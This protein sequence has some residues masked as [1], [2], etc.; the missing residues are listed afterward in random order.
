MNRMRNVLCAAAVMLAAASSVSAQT[1]APGEVMFHWGPVHIGPGQAIA[2]TFEL[3]DHFGGPLT[4]PV[5][6]QI[7]DKNGTVIYRN[8]IAV[9]DGNAVS[10][11]IGPDVRTLRSTVPADIYAIVGPDIRLL[12]P[13]LKVIWPPGPTTPVDRMTLTLEVFDVLTG[14]VVSLANNPH[15]IIG[16]LAQ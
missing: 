5:G 14:R 1:T 9:A 4:L 3:T 10:F 6:L 13:C 2:V 11:V 16:V 8:A 12:S 15:A 7:E